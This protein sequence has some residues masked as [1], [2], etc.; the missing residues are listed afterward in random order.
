MGLKSGLKGLKADLPDFSPAMTPT[1]K[2]ELVE[3]TKL[4]LLRNSKLFN[5]SYIG[6][7]LRIGSICT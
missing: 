2:S 7:V 3:H 5:S 6:L 4:P 1:S